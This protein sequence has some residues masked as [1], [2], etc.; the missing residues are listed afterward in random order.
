MKKRLTLLSATSVLVAGLIPL[1]AHAKDEWPSKNITLVVPFAA[2]GSTDILSRRVAELLQK[3][4]GQPVVV[5][6]RPGAGSTIATG[7]LARE[8][9]DV[10][11]RIIMASPGHTINAS[12]YKSLPYD[13]VDSF[14]FLVNMVKIPNVMVVPA[15]SPYHNVGEF[16]KAA[17]SKQMSF[18]SSG[19]GSSIHMSGELFK[20][21]THLDKMVHVPYRGSGEALPA[22]LAGD[23]DVTF[24]NLPTVNSLIKSGQVR[25]LA[26]TTE[27]RSSYLKDVPTLNEVGGEYGLK[28]FSTSAWFGVIA[29]KNMSDEAYNKLTE[30]LERVKETPEFKVFLPNIGAESAPEEKEV[31]RDFI[32]KDIR[33]WAELVKVIGLAK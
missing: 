5:E 1:S 15:S 31:F 23:V 28:D 14:R 10:D 29:N 26:V 30:A 9:K 12:I 11:Y 25:A 22:L 4:V 7:Q 32:A 33:Q 24:E 21:Q 3:E 16:I 27:Q 18:S 13:P 20:Y 8:R 6:N 17:E 2:G 19:I